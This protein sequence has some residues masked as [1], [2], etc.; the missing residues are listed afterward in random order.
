MDIDF[1]FQNICV[2]EK[3]QQSINFYLNLYNSTRISLYINYDNFLS[4]SQV[5]TIL[6]YL[7]SM[8]KELYMS[9]IKS[10]DISMDI[11]NS[12]RIKNI[13][14]GNSI[15]I[16]LIEGAKIIGLIAVGRSRSAAKK[17]KIVYNFC[18]YPISDTKILKEI[19][20]GKIRSNPV[21]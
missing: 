15:T 6:K 14:T 10:N 16:E 20:H 11:Q 8:Y 4:A 17:A 13:A 19:C 7:D 9:A 1:Y 18:Q 2:D 5:Q 12:L 3:L 21:Q